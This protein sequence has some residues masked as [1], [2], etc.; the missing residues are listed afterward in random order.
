MLER[1]NNSL[2][3]SEPPTTVVTAE[4]Y[5]IDPNNRS[6]KKQ[7]SIKFTPSLFMDEQVIVINI[8]D[9]TD[10][11][12]LIAA[13]AS[14]EYKTRLLSSVSHELRTPLNGSINFLEQTITEYAVPIA[15]KDKWLI[16]A[17]RCN[18][19][20][21]S[22]VNDILDFSQMHAG[23]LRL[24][25]E[26]KSVTETAKEC[27]ELLEL[28]AQ[29]KQI[30]LKLQN[31]LRKKEETLHTDHNRLKQVMLNLLSNAVKF[32]FEGGV[33]LFLDEV[34]IAHPQTSLL[35][36]DDS[37]VSQLK[38]VKITCQDSGIGI[39]SENQEKLFQSFEKLDLGNH[40][41][42]IN[43]T[44]AGLGLVISNNIVQRLSPEEVTGRE[45]EIIRFKSKENE[46]SSFFFTVY[47]R[48]P[49]NILRYQ[50]P[51][52][53]PDFIHD[54]ETLMTIP[55]VG[56]G[57]KNTTEL[58]RTMPIKLDT[59]RRG[60]GQG[61][62]QND[63]LLSPYSNKASFLSVNLTATDNL[64]NSP[65][66]NCDCPKILIVDDDSFNLTALDQILSKLKIS[67][68]WAFNGKQAIEKIETRQQN[69]CCKTCYQ[70]KLMFLDCQMPVMDGF[71]TA[72]ALKEMMKKREIDVIKI[73]ACTA[74]VQKSDEAKAR[75]SGMDDFCTKPINFAV[76]KEKLAAA[77][78]WDSST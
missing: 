21:L 50:H 32:T 40:D 44:G 28:Q 14:S 7:F 35:S 77:G 16:P 57:F 2:F 3:H 69:R 26:A 68:T 71:E 37:S 31:N 8:T 67:C 58:M 64:L 78:F 24:V 55:D 4:T 61:Q 17:L 23:K 47:N 29:K 51:T 18:R 1:V 25:F 65:K 27:I 72:K 54:N 45:G 70:Y 38:G 42:R 76:I 39:S 6:N 13:E 49:E 36:Y 10:R 48:T 33:T 52:N 9:T 73:V 15:V 46:G 43:A 63:L 12:S 34:A 60:R 41:L 75:E 56:M 22:L 5:W 30:Q 19:L 74:F 20:L 66:I 53:A 11:D 59:P 62:G